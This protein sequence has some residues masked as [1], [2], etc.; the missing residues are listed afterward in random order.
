MANVIAVQT[1]VD[2]RENTVIKVYGYLDTSDVSPAQ[3]VVDPAALSDLG[4]FA[5]LKASQLRIKQVIYDVEDSLA[6]TLLWDATTDM[7]IEQ[8]TGAGHKEY[9]NFGGLQNNS[10]AGRTGKIMLSTQGWATSAI[11]TF[12]LEIWLGKQ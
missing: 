6:V 9:K 10:G 4:P 3:A 11:L 8:Y 7:E 12:T 5:G 1:L 2:G